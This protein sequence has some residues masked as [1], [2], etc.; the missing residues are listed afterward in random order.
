MDFWPI[1]GGGRLQVR[2]NGK[3]ARQDP[4]NGRHWEFLLSSEPGDLSVVIE[5]ATTTMP[6][7]LRRL[8]VALRSVELSA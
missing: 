2:V 7:D 5:S 1:A 8:G 3:A 6:P 4:L